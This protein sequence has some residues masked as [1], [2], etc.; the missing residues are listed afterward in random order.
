MPLRNSLILVVD[1]QP[2]NLQAVASLLSQ[3]GFEVMPAL[4][5]EQALK[6][7]RQRMP[8]LALLDMRM[9]GMDGA[10][11]C[12][13]LMEDP[14]SNGLPVIF[15]TAAH[16]RETMIES[17]R[18]GAVDYVTKPF[19]SEELLARVK[20]HLELKRAR[21]HLALLAQERAD[22]TQIV[23]HDLKNPLAGILAALDGFESGSTDAVTITRD[24]RGSVDRCLE[25]ID[26]YLGRWA[27]SDNPRHVDL[28]EID[29]ASVVSE[30]VRNLGVIAAHQNVTIKLQIEDRPQV[31]AHRTGLRHVIDNLISNSLRYAGTDID[32]SVS[33]GRSG[34]A[35]V[36]VADRGPGVPEDKRDKLF[37]RYARLND[38]QDS[39][40]HSSGLGLAI[41]SE[42]IARMSGHLWYAAR[43]G[44]GAQFQF[45]LPLSEGHPF[46]K[47][48]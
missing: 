17:F 29:L 33:T 12:R 11:L 7:C 19:V 34:M 6:R 3:A 4:S 28:E 1:D 39:P 37:K 13:K 16:E 48:S 8:D 36:V 45:V 43:D 31:K 24:I 21:D 44:G 25:F 22:L 35:K 40:R 38:E 47:G 30:C 20:T 46:E 32:V 10:A 18:L 5:G 41:S 9:P 14:R 2:P 27:R 15:L 42:E 26:G 23:A